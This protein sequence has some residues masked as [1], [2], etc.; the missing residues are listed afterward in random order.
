MRKFGRNQSVGTSYVPIVSAGAV[1]GFMPSAAAATT[2]VSADA[3][4]TSD[5]TGAQTV[6]VQGVDGT[7]EYVQETVTLN[8]GTTPALT[9][10]YLFIHRMYVLTAGTSHVNEGIIT[11]RHGA[12]VIAQ[13]DAGWSQTQI[14]AFYVNDADQG[15]EIVQIR[16]NAA[17]GNAT[18]CDVQFWIKDRSTG[19]ERMIGMANAH[20]TQY[21]SISVQF[22]LPVH[23]P[24]GHYIWAE[25][26]VG[27]TTADVGVSFDMR[28]I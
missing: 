28:F 3:D 17:G 27:G 12:T 7:G 21:P 26:K 24:A 18:Q 22:A 25:A 10:Q 16:V 13:I 4:D 1:T 14:A 11:A 8:G 2:L 5:G 9:H 15:V 6:L 19:V 23:I 20:G